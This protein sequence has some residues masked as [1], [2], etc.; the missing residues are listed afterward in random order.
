MQKHRVRD[1]DELIA[2]RDQLSEKIEALTF[3]DE[4]IGKLEKEQSALLLALEQEAGV[5]HEKRVS[6]ARFMQEKVEEQLKQLGI[7]NARFQVE[8]VKTGSYLINGSD[9]VKVPF[10]SQ[11]TAGHLKRFPGWPPGVKFPG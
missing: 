5:L 9:Q 11:Q 8:L 7:P 6:S 10:L 2:L 3:S 1:V 4:K